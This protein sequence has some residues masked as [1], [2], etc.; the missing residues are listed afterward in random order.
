MPTTKHNTCLLCT[1][2]DLEKLEHYQ[3]VGLVKCKSCNFVFSERIPTLGDLIDYYSNNYQ[4]TSYLSP[5]T[6]KR[7]NELLDGFEPF[8]KTGKLLDVGAGYG[9]FLEIARER[10]W[11]VHGTELTEEAVEHCRGKGIKMFQGEFH[12]LDL[13]PDSYDVIVSIE[14]IEHINTPKDYVST[15]KKILRKGGLFYLT[16]PNFNSILRYRLKEQYNVIEYPNHLCYYTSRTLTKLFTENGFQPMNMKTTGLSLTRLLT[17]KDKEKDSGEFV[18]E[19]SDDEMLRFKIE[20][21]PA[22]RALKYS[23][24]GMLNIL[25]VGDSLKAHFIK[26]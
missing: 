26:S 5:I 25:N 2:S 9:F 7:Y 20:R 3:E 13:D 10:G 24:N 15:A 19:T 8:R 11:E 17:S 1:S 6:V 16:T 4:R 21:N 22:L 18:C 14:V 12:D 23:T